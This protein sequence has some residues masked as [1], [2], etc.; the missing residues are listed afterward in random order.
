MGIF[1]A[2]KKKKEEQKPVESL[3]APKPFSSAVPLLPEPPKLPELDEIKDALNKPSFPKENYPGM[4]K[5]EPM[6]LL[7]IEPIPM[8]RTFESIIPSMPS[9]ERV[10]PKNQQPVTE[11][12]EQELPEQPIEEVSEEPKEQI[13]QPIVRKTAR[14]FS[15]SPYSSSGLSNPVYVKIETFK[16]ALANFEEIKR[17]LIASFALL[18]KIKAIREKEKTEIE[19]WEKE[20]ENIKDM[21]NSINAKIFSK[22]E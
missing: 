13:S 6:P 1:G 21:L 17:K 20:L 18:D 22:V 9:K 14:E 10:Q 7:K 19:E 16:E 4:P 15:Y 8:S 5:L 3:E 12:I 2:G 11:E